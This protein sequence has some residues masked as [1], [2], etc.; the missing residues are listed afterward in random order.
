[1]AVTD[2]AIL[3]IKEMIVSGELAPG[4]RLPREADLAARLGLARNS[5]REAVRALALINIL[6][7][8]Q[9]DGTYVTSLE[10][11]LLLEALNFVV[12][13]H[14][15]DSVLQFF[16][17]RRIM[18][19]AGAAMAAVRI[20]D[21]E[22]SQLRKLLDDIDPEAPVEDLVASDIEFHRIVAQASGNLVL[23]SLVDGLSAPTQRARVWRG[24]TE[25]GAGERT[26]N[27]HQAIYD[28]LAQHQPE[29]AQSWMT[30]HISGVERWLHHAL[31]P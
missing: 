3:R 21:G 27:E 7:V 13:F 20:S 14:S 22:L 29:L 28:A 9:G 15:D 12:D 18:E 24:L 30:V 16:E 17:V 2:E 8:R 19:P 10:S 25:Q 6:D 26:L 1:M 5:L 4:D 23:A 11:P 31:A